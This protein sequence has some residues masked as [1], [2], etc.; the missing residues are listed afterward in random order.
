M[1]EAG[2]PSASGSS[3]SSEHFD[4]RWVSALFQE[5]LSTTQ[6]SEADERTR[7]QYCDL[8]N[9]CAELVE[10]IHEPEDLARLLTSDDPVAVSFCEEALWS[11]WF[12]QAGQEA[13]AWL[14]QAMRLLGEERMEEAID[15]LDRLIDRYPGFAEAYHQR[16]M[17]HNLR[18]DHARAMEDFR[19]TLQL[20]PIHF[21][22]MANLGHSYVQLGGYDA[23]R[24]W[25]LAALR[26]YPRMPGVRQMLRHLREL[27]PPLPLED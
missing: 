27:A 25:Y 15:M 21:A 2:R 6:S 19:R 4:P 20:N 24:K 22:A 9:T 8:A 26:V 1:P 12:Q 7:R 11:V 5:Q 10:K 3:P 18:D 23:A 16:G 14:H 17:A 13:A